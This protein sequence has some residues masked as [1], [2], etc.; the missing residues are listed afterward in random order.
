MIR[1]G[2][3]EGTLSIDAEGEV[4]PV[5]AVPVPSVPGRSIRCVAP[6]PD[7]TQLVG[8]DAAHLYADGHLVESF[9]AI[10]TRDEWYTPWGA[11]PDVR[12]ATQAEDGTVLVNVHVGGV[13]RASSLSGPWDEVVPIDHDTHQVLA[14][15]DDVVVCAAAI[16][17]GWSFDGGRTFSW[18]DRGLHASYCRAVAV[19][20][21]HALVTASTGPRTT[22][23]AVYRREL[24]STEPFAR[25]TDGLPATF[26][27]NLD[28]FQLAADASGFAAL[29]TQAGEVYA[30]DDAG[31]TW[32]LVAKDLGPISWVRIA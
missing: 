26:P 17:F 8:T 29:G 22:S 18:T 30:S 21:S 12:S 28:T 7:G 4:R 11:P 6:L 10:P 23:G 32:R 15:G 24:R 1:I 27:Y 16:G 25:C 2:T 3:A 20:G 13:W 14:A 19:A 31:A 5:E 9:D